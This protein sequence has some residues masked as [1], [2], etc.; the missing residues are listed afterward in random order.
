M[1]VQGKWKYIQDE[2]EF[3]E[4]NIQAKNSENNF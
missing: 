4:K 3:C 2:G 1:T